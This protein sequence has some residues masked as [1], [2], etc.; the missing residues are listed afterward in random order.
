M[1]DQR[2]RILRHSHDLVKLSAV[3]QSKITKKDTLRVHCNL[4]NYEGTL[5]HITEKIS[6]VRR[7]R[8]EKFVS[9]NSRYI[10][11]SERGGG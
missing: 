11:T 4:I 10:R 6:P 5:G 9:D 3:R 2:P 7:G 1:P 8:V